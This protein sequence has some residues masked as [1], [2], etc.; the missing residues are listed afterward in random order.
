MEQLRARARRRRRRRPATAMSEVAPR[1]RCPPG[2][3][4]RVLISTC[5]ARPD[6]PPAAQPP[7]AS[8]RSSPRILR[9][10]RLD[11]CARC[12]IACARALP[13]RRRR[14]PPAR[15][16][17]AP[18]AP[19]PAAPRAAP[20]PSP[21]TPSSSPSRERRHPRDRPREPGLPLGSLIGTRTGGDVDAARA[22]AAFPPY[23]NSLSASIDGGSAPPSAPRPRR[24]AQ[25]AAGRE[26]RRRAHAVG[27]PSRMRPRSRRRAPPSPAVRSPT[28]PKRARGVHTVRAA[29]PPPPPSSPHPLRP[30]PAPPPSP[31]ALRRRHRHVSVVVV[32]DLLPSEEGGS[33]PQELVFEV[34][35]EGG[36][37]ASARP[38]AHPRRR[39]IAG[40][41]RARPPARPRRPPAR[42]PLPPLPPPPP[43]PS[44][45]PRRVPRRPR[46]PAAEPEACPRSRTTRH[47]PPPSA[48]SSIL[49]RPRAEQSAA[50]GGAA[51]GGE[52]RPSTVTTRR[53]RGTQKWGRT[54]GRR[55]QRQKRWRRRW[56]WRRGA[57]NVCFEHAVG[58]A[59]ADAVV[60]APR[61]L[62]LPGTDNQPEGAVSH[63]LGASPSA[64]SACSTPSSRCRPSRGARAA[65]AG[66]RRR[67]RRRPR[68]S[69][70]RSTASRRRLLAPVRGRRCRPRAPAAA[71]GSDEMLSASAQGIF[72]GEASA[73]SAAAARMATRLRSA[74]RLSGSRAAPAP[75]AAAR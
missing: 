18:R 23:N 47:S 19:R 39:W 22:A 71:G 64:A 21:L 46:L 62:A 55:R 31:V 27:G 8:P 6:R 44:P 63:T 68:T 40:A 17:A 67:R 50:A 7:A 10:S 48:P 25:R 14:R 34:S 57:A 5:F 29:P 49:R 13:Q 28:R 74:E 65:T 24:R 51:A 4:R 16:R 69:R 43:P 66:C 30:R 33:A 1:R 38:R 9:V 58:S 72:I 35:A 15:V 2:A 73:S 37:G 32:A 26:G 53:P 20:A 42:P 11:A 75:T 52:P 60:A 41:R 3:G 45:S 12:A 54:A 56:A 70:F 59:V 61:R 36:C